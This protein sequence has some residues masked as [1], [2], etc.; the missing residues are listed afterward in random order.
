MQDLH[1]SSEAAHAVLLPGSR[2][3]NLPESLEPI[4][5]KP[6][7]LPLLDHGLLTD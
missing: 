3:G 5:G 7:Y 1:F 4:I 6:V 2:V